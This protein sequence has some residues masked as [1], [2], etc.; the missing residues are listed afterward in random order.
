VN[1]VDKGQLPEKSKY[2]WLF[3]QS[4]L[5]RVQNIVINSLCCCRTLHSELPCCHQ[6]LHSDLCSIQIKHLSASKFPV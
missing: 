5:P 1:T 4:T 6:L 2:N 3:V